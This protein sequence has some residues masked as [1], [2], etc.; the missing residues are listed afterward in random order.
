MRTEPHRRPGRGPPPAG[1]FAS[2]LSMGM[3]EKLLPLLDT[4]HPHPLIVWRSSDIPDDPPPGTRV[5][6]WRQD[7]APGGRSSPCG[8][9]QVLT[10]TW[11]PTGA[12]PTWSAVILQK[13]R[14]DAG[15]RRLAQ[16]T[17]RQ[18]GAAARKR[19]LFW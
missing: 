3:A 10:F 13:R 4:T 19:G 8:R 14:I 15:R 17:H 16:V 18:H 2:S 1:A 9:S 11:S 12:G 7:A 5:V 6:V